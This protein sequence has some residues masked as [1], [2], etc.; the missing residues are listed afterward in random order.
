VTESAGFSL[1]EILQHILRRANI[2]QIKSGGSDRLAVVG[3]LQQIV[4]D[5]HA[6][7]SVVTPCTLQLRCA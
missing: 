4:E 1:I 6:S 7:W 5:I 2:D 3:L